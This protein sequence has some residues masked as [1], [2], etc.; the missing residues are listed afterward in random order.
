MMS[1]ME[2]TRKPAGFLAENRA[3]TSSCYQLGIRR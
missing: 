3:L 1:N 2:V